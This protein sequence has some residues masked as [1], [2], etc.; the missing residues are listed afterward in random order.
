MIDKWEDRWEWLRLSK[1]YFLFTV[2]MK[3]PIKMMIKR[4]KGH[5]SVLTHHCRVLQW[6]VSTDED[7][8]GSC[9]PLTNPTDQSGH[10]S[11]T[12]REQ[13]RVCICV[14]DV[15]TWQLQELFSLI[16]KEQNINQQFVRQ[17]QQNKSHKDT[18]TPQRHKN[19]TK[20]ENDHA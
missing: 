16:L 18:K 4:L 20:T 1:A 15:F 10:A 19:A 13:L 9:P 7:S 6:W 11:V 12:L 17:T 8:P 2:H 14:H 5:R 3:H